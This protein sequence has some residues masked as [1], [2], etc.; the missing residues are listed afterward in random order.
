MAPLALAMVYAAW[1]EASR[2]WS[3]ACARGCAVC[4]SDR[5]ALTTLE[6]RVLARGLEQAGRADLLG[7][8]ASLPGGPQPAVT[9]NSLAGLC[10]NQEEPPPEEP[11]SA[12]LGACPLLREGLCPAYEARPL[13]CRV[14]VSGLACQAGGRAQ[15]DPWWLTLAM[16]LHQ[17]VEHLDLGGGY[18]LLPL[19]MASLQGGACPG[20]LP[21][22][23]LPGIPAPA[24]HQARLQTE[25][26]RLL[27]RPLQDR[28]LGW[29]LGALGPA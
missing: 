14:M 23:P 26:S 20:L 28:P 19:V 18:G 1:D 13:G 24:Q 11:L 22:Q 2:E 8:A 4:C 25:L 9:F 17:I 27:G 3:L 16:A 12:A 15:A 6:G 10:L 5:L 21:C 7:R 29:W